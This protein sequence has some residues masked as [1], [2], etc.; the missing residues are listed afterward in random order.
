MPTSL[1]PPHRVDPMF[2]INLVIIGSIRRAA[3]KPFNR[4]A[5]RLRRGR[6]RTFT[7]WFIEVGTTSSAESSEGSGS[8][9]HTSLES[10]P[11]LANGHRLLKALY[12][13][14]GAIRSRLKALPFIAL[15][16]VQ[17][18]MT[19][20]TNEETYLFASWIVEI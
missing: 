13:F 12:I 9:V 18:K 14:D 3:S 15:L 20:K 4:S 16:L 5:G 10:L 1:L 2:E 19:R 6:K 7:R 11:L 17:Q 8:G